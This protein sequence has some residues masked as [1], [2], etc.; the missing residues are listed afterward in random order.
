MILNNLYVNSAASHLNADCHETYWHHVCDFY[1]ITG[2]KTLFDFYV[3]HFTTFVTIL[4]QA[5]KV[6]ISAVKLYISPCESMGTD[7]LLEP[8]LDVTGTAAFASYWV[9]FWRLSHGFI[10]ELSGICCKS[11]AYKYHFLTK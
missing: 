11:T 4:Y 8:L 6:F 10:L 5:M 3:W 2:S 9:S 7:S 1:C